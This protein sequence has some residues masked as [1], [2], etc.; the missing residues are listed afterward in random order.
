MTRGARWHWWLI[1]AGA[2]ASVG[3]LALLTAELV[4]VS[5]GFA[6]VVLFFV[7][8]LSWATAAATAAIGATLGAMRFLFR[9]RMRPA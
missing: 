5:D 9:H 4:N 2:L 8:L 7:I 1:T 6:G 3:F